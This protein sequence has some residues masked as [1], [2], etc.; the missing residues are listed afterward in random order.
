MVP[1]PFGKVVSIHP[2][3]MKIEDDEGMSVLGVELLSFLGCASDGG[4]V[5]VVGCDGCDDFGLAGIVLDDECVHGR[6][7]ALDAW[8]WMNCGVGNWTVGLI[9]GRVVYQG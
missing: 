5:S 7:R 4:F 9:K 2:G 1:E 3:E 6:R 8:L